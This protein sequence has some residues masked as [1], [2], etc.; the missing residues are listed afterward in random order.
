VKRLTDFLNQC[1][2]K[3]WT[4]VL[5]AFIT[6]PTL[7]GC[8]ES[9]ASPEPFINSLSKVPFVALYDF[10]IDSEDSQKETV[11]YDGQGR[12]R[13]EC[14]MP[15]IGDCAVILDLKNQTTDVL[16]ESQKSFSHFANLKK[17]H[18]P[19]LDNSQ[20]ATF[21]A[22]SLGKRMIGTDNCQG[23]Y[24]VNRYGNTEEVWISQ[25]HHM[26]VSYEYKDLEGH[27]R[28]EHLISYQGNNPVPSLFG[29]PS[30]FKLI[31]E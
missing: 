2:P 9:D 1:K 13:I 17:R 10:K 15:M 31:E 26:P 14:Q 6:V 27:T 11:Y 24:F 28:T 25:Q 4:M 29:V 21:K 5:T 7:S 18:I 22:K 30:D 20:A 19:L 8:G 23:W 12:E 16:L 3:Y